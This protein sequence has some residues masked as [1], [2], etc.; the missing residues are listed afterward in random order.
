M[1][2]EG[3]S[4]QLDH[5]TSWDTV[6]ASSHH[7]VIPSLPLSCVWNGLLGIR[8][9]A[10]GWGIA[11][12]DPKQYAVYASLTDVERMSCHDH[13]L[14]LVVCCS[15]V[16]ERVSA[17]APTT[18]RKSLRVS[19]EARSQLEQRMRGRHLLREVDLSKL[20][21][22]SHHPLLPPTASIAPHHTTP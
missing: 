15:L 20:C 22:I 6:A 7:R 4:H 11:R 19:F 8:M 2:C 3:I 5:H 12:C 17:S 18:L 13:R 1:M 9:R 14:D 10:R 16:R 21:T